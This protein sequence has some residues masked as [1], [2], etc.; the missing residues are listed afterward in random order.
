MD[1]PTPRSAYVHV[2]FCRHR[3][4]YCNFSV[5]A[6]RDDLMQRYLAAIDH[7]LEQIAQRL[8]RVPIIDTLFVGGG[9]PTHLPNALLETFLLSLR[10]RFELSEGFEWTMEANPEDITAEKLAML[11]EFGVNRVSL[12]VQSFQD[13]KLAVLERSHSGQSAEAI[14]QQV[15]GTIPNVSIDLIFAAPGES[16]S[17]WAR[18]LRTATALPIRHVSTYSLTYEKGTS[19]W[20][21]RRRGDLS[22]VDESVEITMYD[23]S[24]RV[25]AEAGLT[26]YEISNFAKPGFRCRHNL[27]YWR[28]DGWFAAGP[29]AAAFIDGVRATNHRSTTTYLK[30]IENGDSAIA[31]SETIS[32]AE[33]AREGAAFGV[34]MIDG[35]DLQQLHSRTGIAI[36]TLCAQ[37]LNELQSQGLI[38]RDGHQIKLTPRGIHFADTVAS[39]LL[40]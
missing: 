17:N 19:F 34:R 14:V 39:E 12:G 37:Q 16:L 4:G 8:Q 18:D 9:T 6:D 15:A 33:A 10:R 23:L 32:A 25:L 11:S 24:R 28:G 13:R 29:G 20:T 7:E 2:P 40:G 1:W 27:A 5:V 26:H 31:E 35:I 22:A 21:R 3:C 38:D 36:E 30:R